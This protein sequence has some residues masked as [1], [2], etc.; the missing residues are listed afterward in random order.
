M[1][2]NDIVLLCD[3]LRALKRTAR[4]VGF[5]LIGTECNGD[6]GFD[7]KRNRKAIWNA[8]MI[9]NIKENTRRRDPSKPRRGRPRRFDKKSYTHRFTVERTFGWEDKYRSLVIRY[10]RKAAN[11]RGR[12]LLAY[13]LINLRSVCGKMG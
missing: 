11:Y 1:N 8:G 3:G 7:S 13:A 4:I 5:S 12:K 10:D 6:S 9:P 2:V